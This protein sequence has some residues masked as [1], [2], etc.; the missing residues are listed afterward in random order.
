MAVLATVAVVVGGC[1]PGTTIQNVWTDPTYT[2]PIKKAIVFGI[3]HQSGARR[4]LEDSFVTALSAQG[5][6]ATPSYQLFPGDAVDK[7]E[8]RAKLLAAG[9]DAVIVSKLG[10]KKQ[11]TTYTG[12][13]YW[14]GYYGAWGAYDTGTVMTTE[15]VT[16]ENTVWDPNGEGKL[17]WSCSTETLNPNSGPKFANSLVSAVI[18][19]LAKDGLVPATPPT[20]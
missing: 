1:G 14:G 10:D 5:V 18:P 4:T 7:E 6:E 19:A 11:T 2:G 15:Y 17:L 12:G 20:K 3:V 9:Y 16:F 8:A 13:T